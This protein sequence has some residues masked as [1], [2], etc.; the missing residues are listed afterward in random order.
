MALT[1]RFRQRVASAALAA[2]AI[3][4]LVGTAKAESLLPVLDRP[5]TPNGLA[6]QSVLLAAANAGERLVVVGER[7]IVLFSD[8]HGQHWQQAVV[9]VSVTLTT[10]TFTTPTL[11]WAAG[12]AGVILHTQDGGKT[13]QRQLDGHMAQRLLQAEYANAKNDTDPKRVARAAQA[14][15]LATPEADKPFLALHFVDLNTGYAV[16]A[17]GLLFRT[18]DGGKRWDAWVTRSDNP[19]GLHIYAV[20][21]DGKQLLLAGEQ[22]LLLHSDTD[23]QAFTAIDSGLRRSFFSA[24]HAAGQWWLAGLQGSLLHSADGKKFEAISGLPPISWASIQKSDRQ[25]LLTNQAGMAFVLD[26]GSGK[27]RQLPLAPGFPIATVFPSGDGGL[28]GI[29]LRGVKR[30][31]STTP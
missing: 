16:G 7:G 27:T 6:E 31:P 12:H 18:T 4:P 22:G 5:A 24:S 23:G 10:V 29:G 25:L 1:T 3:T 14:K 21:S 26:P 17:Y 9:P 19:K 28:I 30:L 11:G 15:A 2:L 8:D 13:W 20:A